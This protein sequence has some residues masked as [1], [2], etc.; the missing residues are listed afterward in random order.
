MTNVW[1]QVIGTLQA[2]KEKKTNFVRQAIWNLTQRLV[3]K[4]L[5]W[6][7]ITC[8]CRARRGIVK[9]LAHFRPF[10]NWNLGRV[11]QISVE[12]FVI[13]LLSNVPKDQKFVSKEHKLV[14]QA[15]IFGSDIKFSKHNKSFLRK[16][17][18]ENK[19]TDSLAKRKNRLKIV[20]L[21]ELWI[22]EV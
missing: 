21:L 7:R 5:T 11:T 17:R 15:F 16:Q 2:P 18:N 10:W 6:G 14:R 22:R 3:H 19:E 13:L 8:T 20:N 4:S 12:L 1:L 9:R